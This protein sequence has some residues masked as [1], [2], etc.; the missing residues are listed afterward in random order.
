MKITASIQK[1]KTRDLD[2]LAKKFKALHN[3]YVEVGYFN[4]EM[5]SEA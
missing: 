5:H 4:N 1:G 2:K 3:Q